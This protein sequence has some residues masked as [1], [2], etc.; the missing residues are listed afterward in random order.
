MLVAY[1][2]YIICNVEIQFTDK[3]KINKPEGGIAKKKK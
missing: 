1:I 3:L 2:S